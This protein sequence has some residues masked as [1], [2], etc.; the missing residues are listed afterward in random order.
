MTRF[1]PFRND[2]APALAGLWNRALPDRDVVRPLSVHEFDALVMGKL[3]FDADGLIVAELDGRVVGFAHAGFGPVEPAGPRH[4][5][6]TS[7]G[8]VAMLVVEPGAD[9][10][11][12]ELGLFVEAERYLRRRGATVFYCGGH[13]PLNPFYWGLYGG[14]EFAGVLDA[15][16]AFGAAAL[17]A[18]YEPSAVAT[19]FEA[20]LA[21]AEPR[22]PR[23]TVLRRAYRVEVEDD[24]LTDGWWDALAVG[25]FHPT[26]FLLADRGDGRVLAQAWTWD[27]AAGVA[28]NDGRAR[29][30]LV[31]LEV[32]P[33]HRRRGLGRLL[34][35]ECMRHARAHLADLLCAQTATTNAPALALYAALGFTPTEQA[36]LYRLPASL[37]ERSRD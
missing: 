5:L 15:H 23:L 31:H 21:A 32:D 20:D 8:T 34:V 17:R 11:D 1:R 22:D 26:R 14:S 12:L 9:D 2:D 18:G 28:V 37:S 13:Y 35:S 4:R 27:I 16:G 30:G 33:A 36:T 3:Y 10:P 29:T 25:A 19:L 7:M 24:A 6:D